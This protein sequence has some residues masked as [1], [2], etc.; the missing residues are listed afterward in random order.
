MCLFLVFPTPCFDPLV[1]DPF[2]SRKNHRCLSSV[3]FLFLV[4]HFLFP[5][6][7]FFSLFHSVRLFV[8][9]F[10]QK[11][12][13]F[14]PLLY[15]FHFLFFCL[16]LFLFF[17][18]S[19]F[20]H[21]LCLSIVSVSFL[22]FSTIFLSFSSCSFH[23]FF[24]FS[25]F[26]CSF[27]ITLLVS[28]F[29]SPL[30]FFLCIFFFLDLRLCCPFFFISC[31]ARSLSFLSFFLPFS[32]SL[33]FV[34]LKIHFALHPSLFLLLAFLDL[35]HVF[36]VFIAFFLELTHFGMFWKFLAYLDLSFLFASLFWYKSI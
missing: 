35:H 5:P 30:P 26:I 3:L 2:F 34:F 32:V 10:E 22:F 17:L 13:F 36:F 28:F 15:Q 9:L 18:L 29:F 23:S 21:T 7:K 6:T 16:F 8:S 27:D 12:P 24:S 25:F 31:V 19:C 4:H 20:L 14:S 1:F 33:S 11:L